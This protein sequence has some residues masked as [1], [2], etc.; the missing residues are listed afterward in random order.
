MRGDGDTA[1][2]TLDSKSLVDVI[3]YQ[4]SVLKSTFGISDLSQVPQMW[5]VYKVVY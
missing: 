1:S 4:Q 5:C 3:N 2:P